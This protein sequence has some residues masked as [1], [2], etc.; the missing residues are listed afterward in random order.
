MS[1]VDISEIVCICL[2]FCKQEIT[3]RSQDKD[4]RSILKI[5][6]FSFFLLKMSARENALPQAQHKQQSRAYE[7]PPN[8]DMQQHVWSGQGCTTCQQFV[9]QS[10][11]YHSLHQPYQWLLQ[12]CQPRCA[13]SHLEKGTGQHTSSLKENNWGVEGACLN[14]FWDWGQSKV[15]SCLCYCMAVTSTRNVSHLPGQLC[16]QS[17]CNEAGIHCKG[18]ETHCNNAFA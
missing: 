18:Q 3:G 12:Q 1:W 4:C 2:C 6:W 14:I 13:A 10:L 17:Q 5:I 15:G 9:L 7:Q 8:V 16:P 11:C